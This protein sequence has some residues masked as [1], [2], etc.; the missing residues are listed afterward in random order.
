MKDEQ[1]LAISETILEAINYL[2]VL[3]EKKSYHELY[4]MFAMTIEGLQAIQPVLVERGN[5]D[6]LELFRKIERN[7]VLFS[8]CIEKK[9][10]VD[11]IQIL[12]FSLEPSM[13]ELQNKL[14]GKV[15]KSH[16]FTIGIYHDKASPKEF[17]STERLEALFN[18]AKKQHCDIFMFSSSDVDRQTEKIQAQQ[19]I[20]DDEKIEKDLPNVVYNLFP[21]ILRGQSETEKWLRER[22]PFMKFPV[23]DKLGLPEKLLRE[24]DLGYLFIPFVGVT[25]IEKVLSFLN[26]HK[27]GVLKKA[28]AARGENIF[29]IQQKN[30][31]RFVVEVNKKPILMNKE[32]FTNWINDYILSQ[33][34]ILQ[35]YKVFKTNKNEPYDIRSHVQKD[36]T[37]QWKITKIY[38]RIG[39]KKSILSNISAGGRTQDITQFLIEEFGENKGS[40]YKAKLENLSLEIVQN[41][42][43]VYNYAI[44]ELGLDLAFDETGRIWMHEANGGPQTK[45]HEKERA[46]NAIAYA[47][48]LG[49]NRMFLSNDLQEVTGLRNQYKFDSNQD[50]IRNL[51]KNQT[52]IGLMYDSGSTNTEYLE[53]CAIIANYNQNN[54]YA[55]TPEN[56]DYDNKVIKAKIFEGFEWKERVVRYPDVIYD[57]LR[58][59]NSAAFNVPYIEFTEI[60]FTHKLDTSVLHKV[61]ISNQLSKYDQLKDVIIPYVKIENN[62]QVLEFIES[63]GSIILKPVH[64]SFAVG[65]I[66]LEKVGKRFIWTEDEEVE[67]SLSQLT[68]ILTKRN[69][70]KKYF[71]QKFIES[72]SVDGNPIDIRVHLIKTPAGNW[73]VAKDYVRISESGF[74][75]NTETYTTGR[76]FS[77]QIAYVNRY[78]KRNFPDNDEQLLKEIERKSIE[79][80]ECFDAENGNIVSEQALDLALSLEGEI[81]LIE[82]NANRPGVFGYEYEIARAMI[83]YASFLGDRKRKGD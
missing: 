67:Y 3:V 68:R 51:D 14:S 64:G 43:R 28:A 56:I 78:L 54:F 16:V 49:E 5:A 33:R 66:K 69:I 36:G 61:E 15:E 52:T 71:A 63:H 10:E 83:P 42:D 6:E 21:T 26:K 24:S 82:V 60:P 37:G 81:Y 22:V 74:K 27:R 18:E 9:K 12:Q 35:Q 17:Y 29:F 40:E 48:Y 25:S 53:A 19:K 23:G 7:I 47:K 41:V 44:D 31:N 34:Y 46:V 79:I 39:S 45:Y 75:I 13:R 77:G 50:K 58:M 73:K 8:D 30:E 80:A 2:K 72:K 76:A 32:G 4:Q 62:E 59:K 57:R 20:N 11:M 38:P 70:A 55:F 65:I 1:I